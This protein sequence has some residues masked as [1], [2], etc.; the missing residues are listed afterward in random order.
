MQAGYYEVKWN[1][2]DCND[3]VVSSGIYIVEMKAGQFHETR[4]LV[5]IQ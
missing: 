4:K 5:F 3:S 2:K 1:G